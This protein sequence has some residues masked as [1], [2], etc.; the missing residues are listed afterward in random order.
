MAAAVRK[1][2]D[3]EFRQIII[4][5]MAQYAM[6]NE[7]RWSERFHISRRQVVR[8]RALARELFAQKAQ[9]GPVNFLVQEFN[10]ERAS[11]KRDAA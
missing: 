5:M 2:S 4:E 1:L 11:K 9:N 7:K 6:Y 10:S 8:L 3:D